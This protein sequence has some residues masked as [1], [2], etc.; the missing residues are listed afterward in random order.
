M[1]EAEF[2]HVNHATCEC[3][4][5]IVFTPKYRKKLLF[6]KI[7]RHLGQVFCDLRR[8]KEC[9]IEEGHLMPDHVHVIS[10]PPNIFGGTDHR[11][12]EREEFDMDRAKCRT[13]DA[14]FSG[15]QLQG[16]RIL[17]HDR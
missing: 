9:L 1:M 8:R 10:I 7:K 12:H 5:H 13:Q 6:G 4:Y 11:I 17:C 3:K 2:N 15:T 14:E 16:V